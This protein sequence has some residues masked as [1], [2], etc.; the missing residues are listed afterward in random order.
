VYHR[1]RGGGGQ[2]ALAGATEAQRNTRNPIFARLID[3]NRLSSR[4]DSELRICVCDADGAADD[5]DVFDATAAVGFAI[6]YGGAGR[7]C[8]G[9]LVT[10][11]RVLFCVGP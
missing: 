11:I 1:R 3:V 10:F 2:W 6:I 7:S 8:T 4:G 9:A 5:D